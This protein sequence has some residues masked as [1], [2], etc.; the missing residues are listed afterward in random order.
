MCVVVFG[1]DVVGN[2]YVLNNVWGGGWDF[3]CNGSID[4]YLYSLVGML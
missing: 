4:L 3:G 1:K 2:L